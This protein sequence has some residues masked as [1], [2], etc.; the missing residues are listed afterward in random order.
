M[1]LMMMWV[2]LRCGCC[3]SV[4]V[5]VIF[6]TSGT[7]YSGGRAGQVT[8]SSTMRRGMEVNS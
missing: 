4:G 3:R 7:V 6:A 5:P 2:V 8:I 1:C